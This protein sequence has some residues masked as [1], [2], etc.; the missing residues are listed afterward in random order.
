MLGK[1]DLNE[2][3]CTDALSMLQGLPDESID[4]IVTSP[5]YDGLRVYNGYSFDFDPIARETFRVMK[6]GGVVVWVVG[7]AT[8][9]GSETLTSF[10]QALYFVECGF[11]MHDTMIYQ[12]DSYPFPD[13]TRYYQQFEYMFVLSK[14]APMTVNL[15]RQKARY[16]AT[17]SATQRNNDGTTSPL[18]YKT[19]NDTR[20]LD[21]VWVISAGYMRTT[22]DKEAY[23]H[24]AMFPEALAERHIMTW[25]N[26]G[27]VVLDYF[28]GSGTTA[29]MARTLNRQWLTN[30]ISSE[31]V[32]IIRKRLDR[33]FTPD[34]FASME[35][36]DG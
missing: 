25:S 1:W 28:G 32:A 20:V 2:V 12:K 5:P 23:E 30:D 13:S 34:M 26:P 3:Y 16:A 22:T 9:N 14:G 31:Y 24:P 11:R 29:K 8:V 18:K 4:L 17:K 21:N 10:R 27:D 33:P 7:D 19:G 6:Q 36:N 15:L 35:G